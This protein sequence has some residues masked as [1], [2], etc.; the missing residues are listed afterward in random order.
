M[1]R[2]DAVR[3]ALDSMEK[4]CAMLRAFLDE[5]EAAPAPAGGDDAM[6]PGDVAAAEKVSVSFVL[7]VIK[8][9][10]LRATKLGA[11][12]WRIDRSDYEAWKGARV[13]RRRTA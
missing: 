13:A 8:R 2:T 5:P 3:Q 7:R 9:G 10:E 11:K 12:T 1:T 4:T 6:T